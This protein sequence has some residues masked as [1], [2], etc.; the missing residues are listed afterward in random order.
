[1][2]CLQTSLYNLLEDNN[3][4]PSKEYKASIAS[5]LHSDSSLT[6]QAMGALT[7]EIF[8]SKQTMAYY[9]LHNAINEEEG[10]E[11]LKMIATR[12]AQGEMK[13]QIMHHSQN[14][15]NHSAMYASLI[16]LTGYQTEV[17]QEEK[18]SDF[19]NVSHFYDDIKIHLF[20][21]HSVELRSWC[22]LVSQLSFIDQSDIPYL[23]DMR[24]TIQQIL[25]D[26]V[27][28]VSY[29]AQHVSQWLEEDP[30]LCQ[31][32]TQCMSHTYRE[33]WDYLASMAEFMRD[34]AP[35]FM[36]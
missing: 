2:N 27:R 29:T 5:Y 4:V 13:Q 3:F 12:Y 35:Y 8:Q 19:S 17:Y 34:S 14:D 28:Q 33:T 6:P 9:L 36:V 18:S 15:R 22:L 31:A 32:F 25:D 21:A 23:K 16:P 30:S 10:A 26:E 20:R 24:P 1:M 11:R 7:G